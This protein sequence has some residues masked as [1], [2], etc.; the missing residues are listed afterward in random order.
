MRATTPTPTKRPRRVRALARAATCVVALG[1]CAGCQSGDLGLPGQEEAKD[2]ETR[3]EHYE[4]AALTYY[5]HGNYPR[6]EELAELWLKEVPGDKKA[7]RV[8]ARAKLNQGTAPKLREAEKILSELVRLPWTHPT[9]GD[10]SFEVKSDLAQCY[11]DL[12]DLY[13]RDA[14]SLEADARRG[15]ASGGQRTEEQIQRQRRERDALLGRALPLWEQVLAAN[16]DNPYALAALAKG[17]LQMGNDDAGLHYTQRYLAL[18]EANQLGWRKTMEEYERVARQQGS[19]LDTPQ[20]AAFV[21]R[22]QAV[23]ERTKQMH[24]LVGSVHMRR[25]DYP[26][27]IASYSSVIEIDASVPAAY[28]ERAQAYA[29]IGQFDRAVAD[30][31]EYLGITDPQIHRDERVRAMELLQTYQRAQGGRSVGPRQSPPGQ[32][33]WSEG[34]PPPPPAWPEPSR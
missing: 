2:R 21:A 19:Q 31:E 24:L 26:A 13:H 20:R 22:V 9:R 29:A 12:A 3:I 11:S 30:I 33:S 34:F 10:I 32:P 4:T 15:I 8:L 27:A 7:R 16:P 28:V 17:N 14:L 6:A 23:R 1:A 5:D 18:T 25:Q